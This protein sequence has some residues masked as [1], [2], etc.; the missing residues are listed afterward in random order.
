MPE[1]DDRKGAQS[2]RRMRSSENFENFG[3]DHVQRLVMIATIYCWPPCRIPLPGTVYE[4][5]VIYY[6]IY[7]Y[8]A[9]TYYLAH[10][11][12]QF[13]YQVPVVRLVVP[14]TSTW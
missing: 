1:R 8:V 6:L 13:R 4:L 5:A 12:V 7:T 2:M 3:K 11:Y 10:R 14:G 9:Y